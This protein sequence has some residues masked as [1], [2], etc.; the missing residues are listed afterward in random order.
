MTNANGGVTTSG[1]TQIWGFDLTTNDSLVM[2]FREELATF[3][4]PTLHRQQKAGFYAWE[5][6][7]VACL[8]SRIVQMGTNFSK[9]LNLEEVLPYSEMGIE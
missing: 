5:E 8:D 7:G 2:P 9:Y 3:D 4:D 6:F 1:E